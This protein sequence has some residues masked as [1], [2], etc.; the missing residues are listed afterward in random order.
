MVDLF[1]LTFANEKSGQNFSVNISDLVQQPSKKLSLE[2]EYFTDTPKKVFEWRLADK[3]K[4]KNIY[5]IGDLFV[6]VR[7]GKEEVIT[8]NAYYFLVQP[9]AGIKVSH[10]G[11]HGLPFNY[12]KCKIKTTN[13]GNLIFTKKNGW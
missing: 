3:N 13:E 8:N 2:V 5:L 12:V 6:L 11:L 10:A 9:V 7:E 4:A 1:D